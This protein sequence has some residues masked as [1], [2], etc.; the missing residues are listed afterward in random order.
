M[1]ITDVLYAKKLSGGGGGGS[2]DFSSAEL[3]VR[4]GDFNGAIAYVFDNSGIIV[5][6]QTIEMDNTV[7]VPLYK[8]H[9]YVAIDDPIAG[10]ITGDG[11][12]LYDGAVLHI[13]GNCT[14]TIS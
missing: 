6:Y 4:G 10:T 11:E 7:V 2:S 14:L 13:Y 12:F 1:N 5:A 8:G 3:T 9:L